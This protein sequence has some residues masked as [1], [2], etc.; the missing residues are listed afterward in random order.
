VLAISDH[1]PQVQIGGSSVDSEKTF[2]SALWYAIYTK[3]KNEDRADKNL[4]AWGV[5]TLAPKIKECR[6]NQFTNRPTFIT[7]P[8]FPRYIFARFDAGT[9]LRKVYFTRGVHSVVNINHEPVPIDDD[10]I[11]LI[12]SRMG[13]NGIVK[14]DDE[15]NHGDEITIKGGAFKGL[16]GIF[17]KGLKGS[18]RVMIF[19]TMINYQAR[20]IIERTLVQKSDPLLSTTV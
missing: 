3:P 11:T 15:F 20:V 18:A 10:T 4:A 5:E 1:F 9:L 17:N 19:L 6:Q 13:E 14:M 2:E 7:Q 16:Q 12:K 8:L